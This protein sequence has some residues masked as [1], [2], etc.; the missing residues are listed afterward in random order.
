MTWAG[1]EAGVAGGLVVALAAAAVIAAGF[2]AFRRKMR[3]LGRR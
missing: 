2:V 1:L 3:G